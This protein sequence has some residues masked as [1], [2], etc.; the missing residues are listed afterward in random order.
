MPAVGFHRPGVV[1]RSLGLAAD[2]KFLTQMA[3]QTNAYYLLDSYWKVS[4][5]DIQDGAITYD[6]L[7]Q[8]LI[9]LVCPIGMVVP[10]AGVNPPTGWFVCDGS[11]VSRTTYAA[12]FAQLGTYWGTGDNV[13]TF[14]IPNFVNRVPVGYGS[15]ASWGFGTYGGEASHQLSIAEMP[16]HD[17]NWSQSAHDHGTHTHSVNPIPIGAGGNLQSGSGWAIGASTTAASSVPASYANINFVGQ[18]GWQ[19]HQNMP[20]YGVLYYI[21]KAV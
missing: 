9:N 16:G 3:G 14:N 1:G 17:H 5:S 18:G 11:A 21:L 19:A 4:T 8:S 13:S 20:P 10:F 7:A 15:G 6:K 2:G 12:L